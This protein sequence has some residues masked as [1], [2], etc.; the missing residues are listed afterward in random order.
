MNKELEKKIKEFERTD[1]NW[2]KSGTLGN[3]KSFLGIDQNTL[4]LVGA[5]V[6][7]VML[8]KR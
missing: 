2:E 1:E 5:G 7:F 8:Q 6:A 4:L 3:E